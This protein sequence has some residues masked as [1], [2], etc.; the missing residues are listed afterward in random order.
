MLEDTPEFADD[1]TITSGT[2]HWTADGLVVQANG[3]PILVTGARYVPGIDLRV[4]PVGFHDGYIDATLEEFVLPEKPQTVAEGLTEGNRYLHQ[5]AFREAGSMFIGAAE[6]VDNP[7]TSDEWLEVIVHEILA[8][9]GLQEDEHGVQAAREVLEIRIEELEQTVSAPS[10][11]AA[12]TELDS[13]R[14]VLEAKNA[15][16]EG[17]RRGDGISQTEARQQAKE[18]LTD[19]A[20][21]LDGLKPVGRRSRPHPF[22]NQQLRAVAD[23]L[24]LLSPPLKEYLRQLESA[25]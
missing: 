8:L 2:Q 6:L 13:Y 11:S 18:L 24:L 19:A 22:I 23:K 3:I 7:G 10:L 12:I 1:P 17:E 16:S 14:F 21:R 20:T 5:S 9:A 4:R 15:L 25:E